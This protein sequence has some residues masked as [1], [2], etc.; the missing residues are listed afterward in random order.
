MKVRE[1]N[2]INIKKIILTGIMIA[3]VVLVTMF[4][5]IP[6]PLGYFN[7]GDTAIIITAVMLGRKSGFIAGA[8]GSALADVF[9]GAA[10]FAPI[11]F[12]VKGLEGYIIG[13]II[14]KAVK[15]KISDDKI[16][17]VAVIIGCAVMV[18]GYFFGE[19]YILRFFST[20]YGYSVALSELPFNAIQG[21]VSAFVGYIMSTSLLKIKVLRQV[22]NDM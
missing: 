5:K 16:R 12:V 18:S 15:C 6:L 7:L 19:I 9:L 1:G 20:E 11:T 3:L 8:F 13:Y 2:K 4:T 17:R 14:Y 10:Y 22:L 21:G